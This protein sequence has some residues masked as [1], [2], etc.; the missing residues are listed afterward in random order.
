MLLKHNNFW[1]NLMYI[2]EQSLMV[3]IRFFLV[4]IVTNYNSAL[5]SQYIDR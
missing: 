4:I 2:F 3:F 1:F 5:Y